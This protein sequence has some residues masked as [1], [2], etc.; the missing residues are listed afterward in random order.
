MS[1][2]LSLLSLQPH[3]EWGVRGTGTM[4]PVG[5]RNGSPNI[6]DSQ[7]RESNQVDSDKGEE[8]EVRFDPHYCRKV[9]TIRDPR[10]Y[11]V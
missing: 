8:P 11:T 2:S 9:R 6:E 1:S 10:S 7:T 5:H 3:K 4:T